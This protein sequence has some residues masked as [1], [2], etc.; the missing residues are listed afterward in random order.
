MA[1]TRWSEFHQAAA[2]AEIALVFFAGYGIEVDLCNFLVPTD[3]RRASDR[4]IRLGAVPLGLVIR[5]VAHA[6]RLGPVTLDASWDNPFAARMQRGAATQSI[7]RGPARIEPSGE[8]LEAYTA[9]G[10]GRIRGEG[11]E[12]SPR[13]AALLHYLE[14]RR[15]E[16]GL[17]LRKVRPQYWTRRETGG[18]PSPT[19]RCRA[20][21]SICRCRRRQRR[22]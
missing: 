16:V 2:T 10:D 11:L 6:A 15:L 21:A 19:D 8:M 5:S 20:R 18:N 4:D 1:A 13:C 12:Q 17:L 14:E 22:R 7:E 3:A 9:M